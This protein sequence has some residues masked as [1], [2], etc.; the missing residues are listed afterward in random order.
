VSQKN[1][2]RRVAFRLPIRT[3]DAAAW[4][5]CAEFTVFLEYR[6]LSAFTAPSDGAPRRMTMAGW[7]RATRNAVEVQI[8]CETARN[9]WTANMSWLADQTVS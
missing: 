3:Q 4:P 5:L 2:D 1:P 7:Q 9:C 6:N 8:G